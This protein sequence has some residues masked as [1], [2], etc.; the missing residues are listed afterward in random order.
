MKKYNNDLNKILVNLENN[1]FLNIKRKGSFLDI[2]FNLYRFYPSLINLG[3]IETTIYKHANSIFK[4]KSN[5]NKLKEKIDY[6]ALVMSNLRG[7]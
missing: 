1:N 4:L 3:K 2:E 6:I 5:F 7:F